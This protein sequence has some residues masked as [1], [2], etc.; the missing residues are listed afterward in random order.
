[1]DNW[2]RIIIVGYFVSILFLVLFVPWKAEIYL[3]GYLRKLDMGYSFIFSPPGPMATV[4]YG[5]V[6]MEIAGL[7][8]IAGILYFLS[9]SLTELFK[10]IAYKLGFGPK[11]RESREIE[12]VNKSPLF[13]SFTNEQLSELEKIRKKIDMDSDLFAFIIMARPTITKKVQY[14]VYCGLKKKHPEWPEKKVLAGILLGRLDALRKTGDIWLNTEE[15]F[16]SA[17]NRVDTLDD[18]CGLIIKHDKEAEGID[19]TGWVRDKIDQILS[20]QS[21]TDIVYNRLNE[22]DKGFIICIECNF[23]FSQ[24]KEKAQK[25]AVMGFQYFA[26]PKCGN[27]IVYPLTAGYRIT[28][29]SAVFICLLI[30]ANTFRITHPANIIGYFAILALG[31]S[32]FSLFRDWLIRKKLAAPG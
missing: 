12:W 8:A 1:M 21:K 15:E 29:W 14:E 10:P 32:I 5:I 23:K 20:G 30:I 17:I 27:E 4:N 26:C 13:K 7:T 18:L 6:S 24:F 2:K 3:G 28:C 22:Y 11:V 19:Q 16:V 9:D 31:G 25:R